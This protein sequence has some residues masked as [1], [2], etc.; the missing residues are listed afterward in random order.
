MAKGR[1][2]EAG[3]RVT[4][5]QHS[6][7]VHHMDNHLIL[8]ECSCKCLS[9]DQDTTTKHGHTQH[10]SN[11]IPDVQ[12]DESNWEPVL[13]LISGLPISMPK[14]PVRSH[15]LTRACRADGLS[16]S[17]CPLRRCSLTLVKRKAPSLVAAIRGVINKEPRV[18]CQ[19][20]VLVYSH[21]ISYFYLY[22]RLV[23]YIALTFDIVCTH[24]C[25]MW[26][27]HPHTGRTFS[28]FSWAMFSINLVVL[29]F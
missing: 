23:F 7:Q 15:D 25:I 12:V 26:M 11:R 27:D 10:R 2:A 5:Q 6:R 1:C 22:T 13:N 18:A 28:I 19:R 4:S 24:W 9:S 3:Y 14:F 29:Q 20:T 17:G 16:C 8:Y 21:F